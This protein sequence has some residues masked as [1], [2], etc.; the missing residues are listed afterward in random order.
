MSQSVAHTEGRIYSVSKLTQEIKSLLE[1]KYP[2]VWITGEIS[3]LGTPSSGHAY[4]TLRDSR[5]QI[6]AVMFRGQNRQLKFDLADGMQV[7]GLARINVYEPRGV[8]QLIFEFLEP[9]GAGALQIAFEQLKQRLADEGLFDPSRKRPLPYLPRKLAL[10]TSPT[11]AVIHDMVRILERRFPGL[12]LLIIPVAVQGDRAAA[13]I[14]EALD[15]LRRVSDIDVAILARGGGSIEDLQAFNDESVAR[16]IHAASVPVISAVGHETDFTIADFVADLRAPTP[17]AAAEL[18]VP[19]RYE[20]VRRIATLSQ[21][22]ISCFNKNVDN[23]R[24]ELTRLDRHLVDPRKRMHDQRIRLDEL[25]GRLTRTGSEQMALRRER[26]GWRIGRLRAF[27]AAGR[28]ARLREKLQRL[29]HD[30]INARRMYH[31]SR[32]Q[33]LR[34]LM[35]QLHALSPLAILSRGYSIT[36]TV[37]QALVVRDCT[38]V[39]PGQTLEILLSRGALTVRV[40]EMTNR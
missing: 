37:P 30:L 19:L 13:E 11:G 6:G 23:L 14:V 16:A 20:L 38:Q 17:S 21:R 7:T 29:T 3:N 27:G 24:S 31:R 5:A 10:I 18:V 8:Y 25:M 1:D 2:F 12:S 28:W 34:E 22:L 4:F 35:A 36:R 40:R 33:Q 15:L 26:L 9:K 39:V 32:R